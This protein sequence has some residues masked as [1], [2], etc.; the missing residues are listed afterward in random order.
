VAA[1]LAASATAY[2]FVKLAGA[3]YLV[4]LG[5]RSLLAALSRE[6]PADGPNSAV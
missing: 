1:V 5:V 6:R 2:S 4:Y 3:A